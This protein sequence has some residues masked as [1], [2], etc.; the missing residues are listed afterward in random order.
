MEYPEVSNIENWNPM[1]A[2]SYTR[3]LEF[4][5]YAVVQCDK[6]EKYVRRILG[7][8]E[9]VQQQ[10][11]SSLQSDSMISVR[12]SSAEDVP[13]VKSALKR[14]ERENDALKDEMVREI[15]DYGRI[16]F[17]GRAM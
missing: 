13:N 3:M 17:F 7:L 15:L 5:L 8:S 4:V 16:S 12:S 2:K 14:L 10:L 11:M 6:K 9:N 1:V